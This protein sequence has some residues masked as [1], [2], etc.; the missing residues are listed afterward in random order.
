[1]HIMKFKYVFNAYC[2]LTPDLSLQA[3]N[4]QNNISYEALQAF[5]GYMNLP[6]NYVSGNFDEGKV[7]E[8][9]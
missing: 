1:M 3:Y 6:Y 7:C 8:I 9:W 2:V 4:C 5:H